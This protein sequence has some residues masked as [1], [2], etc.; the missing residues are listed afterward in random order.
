MW[1]KG[2]PVHVPCVQSIYLHC[3][4]HK[5]GVTTATGL[6]YDI[7]H[8]CPGGEELLGD[9]RGRGWGGGGSESRGCGGGI[10]VDVYLH[11]VIISPS[12]HISRF[13]LI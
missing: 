8:P 4:P 1:L 9:G 3:G 11:V 10:H 13:H 6:P 12:T 5:V 7:L 2:I